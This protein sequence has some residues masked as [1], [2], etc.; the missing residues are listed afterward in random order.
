M[1]KLL[2]FQ[3][4]SALRTSNRAAEGILPDQWIHSSAIFLNYTR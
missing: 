4:Q 1:Q 2:F 3:Q